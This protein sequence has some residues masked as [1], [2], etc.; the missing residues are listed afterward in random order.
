ML[1]WLVRN[2]H[3]M[4]ALRAALTRAEQERE[5]ARQELAATRFNAEAWEQGYGTV[6]AQL[7]EAHRH[8]ATALA[9]ADH[10]S[11]CRV[12]TDE[13]GEYINCYRPLGGCDCG[14]AD[15]TAYLSRVEPTS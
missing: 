9:R 6:K 10:A 4:T 13:H 14:L 3:V 8:L 1:D 11:K 2:G 5:E 7:A 12:A 15:A